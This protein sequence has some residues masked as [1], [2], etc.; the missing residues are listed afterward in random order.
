MAEYRFSRLAAGDLDDITTYT[1][2]NFGLEQAHRY[3]DEILPAAQF[4]AD[5]PALGSAYTTR[6][7]QRFRKYNSGQH[8]LF[9]QQT[10]YGMFVVRVLHLMM[11]FDRHLS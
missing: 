6:A 7:G 10:E 8:A 1:A 3:A 9:Y 4:A 2:L 5:F 11:D